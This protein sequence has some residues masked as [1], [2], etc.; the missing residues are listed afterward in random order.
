MS[1]MEKT[2]KLHAYSEPAKSEVSPGKLA[3]ET[4]ISLELAKIKSLLEEEK[5]KSLELLKTIVQL[6]ESLKQEQAKSA[7]LEAKLNRL[8]A[9]E[10]NQLAKKNALLEEEKNRSLEQMRTIDQLRESI[11][12]DHARHAEMEK[13]AVELQAKS[14]EWA[15]LEAKV[16]DMSAALGK[17]SIIATAGKLDGNA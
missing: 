16:K 7:D 4:N 6:R 15:V 2:V 5:N 14:K 8:A 11:K 10:E 9:V 1:S 3:E 17:I 12:Q 13:K